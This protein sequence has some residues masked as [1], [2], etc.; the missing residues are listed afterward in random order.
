MV[1][2]MLGG[3]GYTVDVCRNGREAVEYYQREWRDIDLV[4]LDM[5]MP[6]MAGSEAF[7]QMRE[8]NPDVPVLIASGFSVEREARRMLDEGAAG[9]IQKP[10]G[11]AELSQ[12]VAQVLASQTA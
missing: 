4:V 6:V 7:D 8:V 9:F 1:S 3:L 12:K 2:E 11:R 10:F 5:V